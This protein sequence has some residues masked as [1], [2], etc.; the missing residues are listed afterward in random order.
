LAEIIF[1]ATGSDIETVVEWINDEPRIAW[2]VKEAEINKEYM[3]R[4]VERIPRIEARSY[5]LWHQDSQ[6]L[7]IPS[8]SLD[9]PDTAIL[10]P[11]AGWKQ[12]LPHANSSTPWFGALLPGPYT[13]I[14]K[15]RGHEKDG[16]IG[17]SGFA[18]NG[19]YFRSIG[20][21]A[22][23]AS[24]KWWNRLRR[25]IKKEAIGVP[26]PAEGE[27]RTGAYAFPEAYV[28]YRQGTHLDAN[29]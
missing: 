4:A 26:W 25:F 28:R 5:S 18:W 6:S 16:A 12:K 7:V 15:E 17:R 19:N 14:Y 20:K 3:W 1:Y 9:T 23:V 22:D 2:I 10:N 27:G 8:G 21:G 11:F 24:E 29:P 13:L